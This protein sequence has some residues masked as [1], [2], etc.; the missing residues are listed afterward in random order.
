[1]SDA[2]DSNQTPTSRVR[3]RAR[4]ALVAASWLVPGV[5]LAISGGAKIVDPAG[6]APAIAAGLTTR[7]PYAVLLRLLGVA[8]LG[9]AISLFV[10]STRRFGRVAAFVMLFVFSAFVALNADDGRFIQDCGCFG[11]LSLNVSSAVAPRVGWMLARNAL[12]GA[13]LTFGVYAERPRSETQRTS[14]GHAVIV[15][16][17][18]LLGTMYVAERTM[19]EQGRRDIYAAEVGHTRAPTLGWKFPDAPFLREDGEPTTAHRELRAGDHLLFF[20]TSCPICRRLAPGWAE[21]GHRIEAKGGR[22]VLVAVED[23]GSVAEFKKESGCAALK[24]VVLKDRAD[25]RPLGVTGVPQL[26]ALG[27]DFEVTFNET[28]SR[29]ATFV[30]G[31]RLAARRVDR[32]DGL[33]WDRIAATCFESGATAG[34][35]T[36]TGEVLWADVKLVGATIGRLAIV[37]A[38][39][40]P[41]YDLELAV[42]IDSKG[43]IR[44]IVPLSAG[45]YLTLLDPILRSVDAF[46]GLTLDAA[47]TKAAELS[48]G[49]APESIVAGVLGRTL[50]QLTPDS[51]QSL[52]R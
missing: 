50:F 26:M 2:D 36:K 6:V 52:R 41:V 9:A 32:L 30:D 12:I 38:A 45:A 15:G 23:D 16:A 22:L 47:I 48:K 7:I 49:T 51:A 24:H 5:V 44:G 11:P 33:V 13:L 17:I 4:R 31:I 8:E 34:A 42:G 14:A 28:Q 40:R 10:P 3:G 21:L 37:H 29:A 39:E 35:P 18:V 43:T 25:L 46:V 20:R 27:A 19:R 1:M